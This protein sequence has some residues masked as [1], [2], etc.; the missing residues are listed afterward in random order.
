LQAILIAV[1][2]QPITA[3]Q[4]SVVAEKLADYLIGVGF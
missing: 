2:D 1:Y 3:G 4:C